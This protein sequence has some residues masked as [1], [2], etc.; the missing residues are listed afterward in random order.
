MIHVREELR[1]D[2]PEKTVA[3][4]MRIDGETVKHVVE[5]RRIF[6]F[7][8]NGRLYY[9]KTHKGVGWKEIFKN[10]LVGKKPVLGAGNEWQAIQAFERLDVPTMKVA[11]FGQAGSNPARIRSFIITDALEQTEDLEHFLP[12]LDV[13]DRNDVRL[14]RAIIRKLAELAAKL[15][16]NGINHRDFYLCHFRL[17]ITHGKPPADAVN[18]YVMDLH[19][20]QQR[21]TLPIRWQVKDLAALL[22]SA[23]H[24]CTTRPLTLRDLLR[25]IAVYRHM[26][27]RRSLS[28]DRELWCAVLRR[29]V[30]LSRRDNI[31]VP[32]LPATLQQ[33]L[34]HK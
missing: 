16:G 17:D 11:A 22:Y 34:D 19:R 33:Y 26:P 32:H 15:H 8:R 3:D 5:D 31:P 21:I 7:R 18:L 20:V 1:S 13:N 2:F 9:M 23:L 27:W 12:R 24:S 10:L 6:R 4:F 28:E 29:A 25:F 14:K 30:Q